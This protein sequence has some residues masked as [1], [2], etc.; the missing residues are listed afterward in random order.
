MFT[1]RITIL[2][3]VQP[4]K[5]IKCPAFGTCGEVAGAAGSAPLAPNDARP[6]CKYQNMQQS[7]VSD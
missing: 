4:K 6:T 2:D 7:S 1:S 3:A 5:N